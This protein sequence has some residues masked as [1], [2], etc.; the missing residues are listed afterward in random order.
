MGNNSEGW[1][2]GGSICLNTLA[3]GFDGGELV[4]LLLDVVEAGIFG[5]DGS[6]VAPG[7]YTFPGIELPNFDYT[8]IVG[9]TF[10]VILDGYI[11]QSKLPT[12]PVGETRELMF[13]W[14]VA[15]GRAIR[16]IVLWADFGGGFVPFLNEGDVMVNVRLHP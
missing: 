8:V 14:D 12:F 16:H 11:V 1:Q 9:Q 3:Q 6:P 15:Q 10:Y 5:E 7:T 2:G 4:T 13:M